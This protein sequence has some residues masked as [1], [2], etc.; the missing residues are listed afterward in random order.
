MSALASRGDMETALENARYSVAA[1][2]R[3]LDRVTESLARSC[4]SVEG[5]LPAGLDARQVAAFELA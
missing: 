4:Q 2:R 3:S 5:S 1:L